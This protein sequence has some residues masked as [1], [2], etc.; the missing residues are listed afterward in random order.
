MS[1]PARAEV[2]DHVSQGLKGRA[3]ALEDFSIASDHERECPL[4]NGRGAATAAYI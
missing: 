1:I 2:L 4:L 3:A